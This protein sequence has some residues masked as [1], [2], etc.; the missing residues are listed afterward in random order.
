VLYAIV[1][2]VVDD[3]V[4]VIDGIENDL[5]EVE[6][7]VFTHLRTNPAERI[8]KLKREVLEFARNSDPLTEAVDALSG[9]SHPQINPELQEYFRDVADHLIRS[10]ARVD[11]IGALLSDALNANLAHV[12]VRQ[13]EDM[14]TIS[15]WVA[16]A[17]IPT[18][19]G[20][21][22]GMNFEHMPELEQ[23]W[24]YPTVLAI[25]VL[26]CGFVFWRFRRAGWIG[27]R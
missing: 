3:Y 25:I 17:A 4:P 16:I 12:S 15:A 18:V 9:G 11:A 14:R 7:E 23:T 6:A 1:D 8:F 5:G 27:P 26:L 22:F 20:A 13:N 10:N 2:R 24:A 21:I 19:I